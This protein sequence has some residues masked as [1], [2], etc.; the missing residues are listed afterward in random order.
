RALAAL[1][2]LGTAAIVGEVV[3]GPAGTV[4]VR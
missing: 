3:A 4:F 1:A 2:D